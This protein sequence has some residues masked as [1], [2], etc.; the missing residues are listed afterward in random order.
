MLNVTVRVLAI[1]TS[2]SAESALLILMN[3]ND[4]QRKNK[5]IE[6]QY[7]LYNLLRMGNVELLHYVWTQ[8]KNNPRAKEK[9]LNQ[10]D[11]LEEGRWYVL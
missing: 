8:L 9:W 10:G 3:V 1:E 4:K 7:T 11:N 2:Q 5:L 6:N